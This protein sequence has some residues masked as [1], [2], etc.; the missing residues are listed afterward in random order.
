[1]GEMINLPEYEQVRILHDQKHPRKQPQ[2]FKIPYYNPVRGVIR[3]YYNS[4]RDPHVLEIGKVQLRQLRP[5]ARRENNQRVLEQFEGTDQANRDLRLH[6][7]R[8]HAAH[9]GEVEVRLQFDIVASEGRREFRI[10]YNWRAVP[11]DAE[12]ARRTIEVAHWVLQQNGVD[13]PI[14]CL[15]YIDMGAGVVHRTSRCRSITIRRLGQNANI[16]ETLWPTI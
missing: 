10:L 16:I 8:R 11:I 6:R 12:I 2:S 14:R 3:E 9:L 1:M 13:L 7:N 15:E 5:D 4:H